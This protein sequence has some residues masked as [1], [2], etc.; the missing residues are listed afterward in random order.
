MATVWL[1]VPRCT[2]CGACTEV[3]PTGALTLVEGKAHLDDALCRECEACIQACPT[4]ALQPV[5]EIKAVPMASPVL[6]YTTQSV[7]ASPRTSML[8]TVVAAGAQLAVQAAPLVLHALGQRVL[9]PRGMVAG[10]GCALTLTGS[11]LGTGRQLHHR[12][13]GGS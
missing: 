8:A 4:G 1:D 10:L 5:L 3:C 9:R 2:G 6:A 12:Q 7:P 13:R 11:L